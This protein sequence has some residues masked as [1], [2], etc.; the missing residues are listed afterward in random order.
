M[1]SIDT[2]LDLAE[3]YGGHAHS[4]GQSGSGAVKG[5]HTDSALKTAEND[6]KVCTSLKPSEVEFMLTQS[7]RSLSVLQITH[8]VMT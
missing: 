1:Q 2:L 5:A 6:L 7:R 8:Q 3:Q 4:L